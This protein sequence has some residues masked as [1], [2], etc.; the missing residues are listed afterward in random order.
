[1]E[2][3]D[4]EFFMVSAEKQDYINKYMYIYPIGAANNTFL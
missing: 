2:I 1:M 4:T 3:E